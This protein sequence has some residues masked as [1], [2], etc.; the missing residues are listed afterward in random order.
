MI[1]SRPSWLCNR[2]VDLPVT[3]QRQVL[4]RGIAKQDAGRPATAQ[5]R[6][7]QYASQLGNNPANQLNGPT[8][9]SWFCPDCGRPP[10]ATARE[11]GITSIQDELAGI[12]GR[13]AMCAVNTTTNTIALA[14]QASQ[15]RSGAADNIE[16]REFPEAQRR[17]TPHHGAWRSIGIRFKRHSRARRANDTL[18]LHAIFPDITPTDAPVPSAGI[19]CRRQSIQNRIYGRIRRRTTAMQKRASDAG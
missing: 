13:G 1:N 11:S 12:R 19:A 14:K 9:I 5:Y 4:R 16:Q 2:W 10:V 15:T 6:A 18:T 8:G 7:G 17:D 3:A